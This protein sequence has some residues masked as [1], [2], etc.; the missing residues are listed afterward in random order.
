M[1]IV[2]RERSG[3]AHKSGDE[4]VDGTTAS[5]RML[6]SLPLTSLLLLSAWD[7]G[8]TTNIILLDSS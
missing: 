1:A 3:K 2:E 4:V 7:G 8:Y 5:I 6:N